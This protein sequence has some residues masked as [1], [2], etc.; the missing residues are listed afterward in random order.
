MIEKIHKGNHMSDLQK[1]DEE[2]KNIISEILKRSDSN[3]SQRFDKVYR[4]NVAINFKCTKTYRTFDILYGRDNYN[5]K[6]KQLK[7][8]KDVDT[9]TSIATAKQSNTSDSLNIDINQF[10]F[11]DFYCPYC[12][13][14]NFCKCGSC[15]KLICCGAIEK[16]SDENYIRCAWCGERNIIRGYIDKLSASNR[17]EATN[18]SISSIKYKGLG[19]T[20]YKSLPE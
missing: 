6:Y 11:D 9:I 15:G 12:N 4:E 17:K 19:S 14:K 2:Q 13:S 18:K 8:I 3:N 20:N 10:D 16:Q 1:F 5:E 7:V